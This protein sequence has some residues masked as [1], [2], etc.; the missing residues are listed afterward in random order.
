[1]H[2]RYLLALTTLAVGLSITGGV[3]SATAPPVGP[4]P[5]GQVTD[6]RTSRDSSISIAL[7]SSSRAGY[8]WR[9]ARRVDPRVAVQAGEGE[10]GR[11]VVVVFKT[12]GSGHVRIAFG[13]TR[14]ESR[15]AVQSVTYRLTV[16]PR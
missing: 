10:I 6:I 2:L 5:G 12:T 11:N 9:L 7:P 3:A 16:T 15:K 4:L 13:L 1:M 14:G 8:V